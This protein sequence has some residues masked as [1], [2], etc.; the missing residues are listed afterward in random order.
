MAPVAALN[1][2]PEGKVPTTEKMYEGVPPL[3]AI[4][5]LFTATPIVKVLFTGQVRTG[6]ATIVKG[7]MAVAATPLA[8]FT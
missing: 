3:T 1:V 7:H 2:R 6:P 8:S 5:G 4:A